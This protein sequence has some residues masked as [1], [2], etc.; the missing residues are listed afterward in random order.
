MNFV[1]LL[2][3]VV[4]LVLLFVVCCPWMQC[5]YA[6]RSQVEVSDRED[7]MLTYQYLLD[8]ERNQYQV[9]AKK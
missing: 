2:L 4:C 1:C 6:V 8:P 5:R 9:K 7:D 3:F